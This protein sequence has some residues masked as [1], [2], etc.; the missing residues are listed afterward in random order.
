MAKFKMTQEFC[1]GF[2]DIFDSLLTEFARRAQDEGFQL[3]VTPFGFNL[4]V[5]LS[6]AACRP[7]R[8]AQAAKLLADME[9]QT[10]IPMIEEEIDLDE[11]LR[12]FHIKQAREHLKAVGLQDLV[13]DL[14]AA[15]MALQLAS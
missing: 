1:G 10:G 9:V 13:R 12:L 15:P 6:S 14:A 5:E 3:S 7:G 8:I 4:V 11:R 2:R